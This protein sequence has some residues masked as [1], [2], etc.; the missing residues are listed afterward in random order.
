MRKFLLPLF[1]L[2]LLL[3]FFDFTFGQRKA[4]S[5]QPTP[6]L[7]Q[8][9]GKDE[10]G[11][12]WQAYMRLSRKN[13]GRSPAFYKGYFDWSSIDGKTSGREFFNGWFSRGRLS[14][15]AYKARYRRGQIGV[16]DYSSRVSRGGRF[17]KGRWFGENVVPGIW[18]ARWIK[19]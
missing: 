17:L 12:K 15:K 8:V 14:F 18:Q 11:T 2:V 10:E 13:F 3:S 16:G 9:S 19:Y 5:V 1:A 7:W 4:K 6:G